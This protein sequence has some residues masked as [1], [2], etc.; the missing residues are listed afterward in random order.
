MSGKTTVM[1][2]AAIIQFLAQLGSFVPCEQA[3][4]SLCDYIFSRLGASDNIQK[5]QSTFM[6]EMTETSEIIRHATKRSLIVLDEIGRGTS[7]FDGISL[8]WSLVEHFV[9]RTKA[10]TLFATHYHELIELTEELPQAKNLTVE[11][12]VTEN[13]D[14]SMDVQFLYNLIEQAA[15]QSYGIYVAKLAGLPPSILKRSQKILHQLEKLHR[16][17]QLPSHQQQLGIFEA[18]MSKPEIPKSLLE[19]QQEIKSIDIN[20]LTPL[21]ALQ[22]LAKL[23]ENLLKNS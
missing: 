8:A 14:G 22:R 5:G 21:E 10:I 17:N 6:V 23:Q 9:K 15:N 20:K 7:T 19:L 11:T 18:Q 2:S 4:L 12:K 13:P 3:T 1:R 16:H